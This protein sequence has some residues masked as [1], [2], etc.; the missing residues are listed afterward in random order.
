MLDNKTLK[1]YNY[2]GVLG[3]ICQKFVAEKRATGLK[4]DVV[5]KKLN[6]M[7][8][9]SLNYDIEKN[10]LPEC[11]VR[12]WIT[13]RPHET[14]SN[15]HCRYSVIRGLAQYMNRIGYVAFYP[16]KEEVAKYSRTFVPYIF[17]H[18]EIKRF[19]TAAN[20]FVREKYSSSPRCHIVMPVIMRVLYC[21][22]LRVSEAVG[23]RIS[24]VDLEMGILTICASKHEKSRYVPVSDE[25]ICVLREYAKTISDRKNDAGY[26]FAAPDSGIYD[27]YTIY[28]AF[29]KVLRDAGI[30]HGGKGKGPRLHDFRHSFAVHSMQKF[31]AEGKDV[32]AMLPKLSAYLGHVSFRYTEPYVRMTAEVYPEIS[33]LLNKR[34][35]QLIPNAEGYHE[36]N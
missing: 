14:E 21:C 31:I 17:T 20:N 18:N 25:L 2:V 32:T 30:P 8:R 24:D 29:R 6:Q 12:D 10:T 34:Y 19:F 11:F 22:G 7:C 23:L 33:A 26:F 13:K 5:A 27:T 3:D 9:D 16:G 35:G 36:D 28:A 4:Y 1:D 15:R